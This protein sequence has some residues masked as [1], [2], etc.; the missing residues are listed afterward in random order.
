M[1]T[2]CGSRSAFGQF[3][4]GSTVQVCGSE[5]H[6]LGGTIMK[7]VRVVRAGTD[8]KLSHEVQNS[9]AHAKRLKRLILPYVS[10]L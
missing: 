3:W 1:W 8:L 5:P 7:V 2:L 4:Y 9:A 10:N 6:L